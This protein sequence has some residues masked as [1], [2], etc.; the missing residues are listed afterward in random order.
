MPTTATESIRSPSG[1]SPTARP[2]SNPATICSGRPAARLH[3]A[4]ESTASGEADGPAGVT[5][6]PARCRRAGLGGPPGLGLGHQALVLGLVNRDRLVDQHD[7]DRVDDLVGPVK[8]GVV[9]DVLVV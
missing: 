3:M 5:V 4:S 6:I 2:A 1:R 8:A 7:R 9:Q